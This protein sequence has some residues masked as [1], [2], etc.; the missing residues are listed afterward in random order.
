MLQVL[1]FFHRHL[2]QLL[3]SCFLH[4]ILMIVFAIVTLFAARTTLCLFYDSEIVP[5]LDLYAFFTVSK[6]LIHICIC[7]TPNKDRTQDKDN[8]TYRDYM[9]DSSKALSPCDCWLDRNRQK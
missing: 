6:E 8:T 5:V 9:L 3:P 4:L 1:H 7:R 2:N